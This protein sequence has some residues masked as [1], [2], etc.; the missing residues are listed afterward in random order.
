MVHTCAASYL[1]QTRISA[2]SAAEQ[3]APAKYALLSAT[4]MLFPV[5]FQNSG[6]VNV[7]GTEF[8]PGLQIDVKLVSFSNVQCH[9]ALH[10][11]AYFGMVL[12]P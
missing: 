10:S 3:Q 1:S 8:T 2:G 7:E 9:D 4:H 5:A 6:T 12:E 11:E